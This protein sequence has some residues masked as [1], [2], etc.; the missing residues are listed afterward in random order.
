MILLAPRRV[1]EDYT[2]T[3][4]T[5]KLES[6]GL[7]DE[8]RNARDKS[9]IRK[10]R[11]RD[12]DRKR[13]PDDSKKGKESAKTEREQMSSSG[14]VAS[15]SSTLAPIPAMLTQDL[16]PDRLRPRRRR[17]IDESSDEENILHRT[18]HSETYSTVDPGVIEQLRP[19]PHLANDDPGLF[20]RML[21]GN[22]RTAPIAGNYIPPWMIMTSRNEQE[23]Q[24]RMVKNLSTS[25]AGVGLLPPT[26]DKGHSNSQKQKRKEPSSSVD[27]FDEMEADTLFMILPM[28]PGETDPKS[29][30]KSYQRPEVPLDERLFLI[31][32]YRTNGT[33]KSQSDGKK[34][35]SPTSSADSRDDRTILLSAFYISARIVRYRELM[36]SGMR[37]PDE[38]LAISG[39]L[40][41]AFR[42]IPRPNSDMQVIAN[43]SSRES[44]IEFIPEG[45]T[46][47]GLCRPSTTLAEISGDGG[48]LPEPTPIGRAVMEMAFI[49]GM[50]LTSFGSI[51]S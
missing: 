15:T 3:T 26:K 48:L 28:W 1:Q 17:S 24:Q 9:Q 8:Q 19:R 10:E 47:L 43:C 4:T 25:F 38:G 40:D 32:S 51:T 12:K 6:H 49:G 16:T 18:P 7:L 21:R 30:S 41:E 42:S 35:R 2:N 29:R 11:D 37:V 46:C 22:R 14:S 34:V 39:P 36:G 13:K 33:Q 45:L 23:E 50:A 44:G 20:K 31:L 5:R 27:I